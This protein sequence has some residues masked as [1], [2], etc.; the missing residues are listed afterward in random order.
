MALPTEA[1]LT[2]LTTTNAQMK[3]YLAGLRNFIANVIGTTETPA[4]GRTALGIGTATTSG[5]GLVELA[6]DAEVL[7]GTDAS[8]V[9]TPQSLRNGLIGRV[10]VASTSGTAAEAP[11][12]P[13]WATRIHFNFAQFSTSGP[14]TPLIQG[15]T[16]TGYETSGYGGVTVNF[17]AAGSVSTA[18]H[19]AGFLINSAGA[20]NLL[21]GRITM[22]RADATNNWWSISGILSV[23]GGPSGMLISGSKGFAA[24]LTGVRVITT[25]TLDGG[26][27]SISWE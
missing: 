17:T 9:V 26:L 8:L 5:A 25:D 23:P 13:S 11:S 22:E 6:T 12:V 19:S 24:A 2:G 21:S 14:A 3:T 20:A 16:A 27:V 4:G 7:A 18:A 1:E 10:N 15:R